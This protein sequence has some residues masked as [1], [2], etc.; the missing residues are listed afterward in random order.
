MH[1]PVC[2]CFEMQIDGA[3]FVISEFLSEYSAYR[4]YKHK[5]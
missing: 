3:V 1:F 2:R 5:D 4:K